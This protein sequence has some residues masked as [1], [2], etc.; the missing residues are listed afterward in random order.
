MAYVPVQVPAGEFI[1]THGSANL[2]PMRRQSN[3]STMKGAIYG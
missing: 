3:L 1:V 2:S